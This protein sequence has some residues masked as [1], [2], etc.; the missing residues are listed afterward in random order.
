VPRTSAE[1]RPGQGTARQHITSAPISLQAASVK[2][3]EHVAAALSCFADLPDIITR[4]GVTVD[5]ASGCWRVG[6]YHDKDGYA[7]I[8][9]EGAHRIAWRALVGEIPPARPVLD[10]VR[11]RGCV[12]RDCCRPDHLEPVTVRTNT[13]RGASFAAVNFRKT[14]CGTCGTEYDLL[15][16]YISPDGRRNCR[17]CNRAAVAAWKAR[18]LEA[19][20]AARKRRRA[21]QKTRPPELEHLRIELGRAA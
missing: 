15:N 5:E 17:R 14:H 9:G 7:R 16:C 2:A 4:R 21:R 3:A 12:W 6:G 18:N 10:H 11:A 20:R 19:V 1:R 13:L 8:N